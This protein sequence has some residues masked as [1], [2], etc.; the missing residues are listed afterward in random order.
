MSLKN[1]FRLLVF[2]G[3][4][5]WFTLYSRCV[6]PLA[7][8]NYTQKCFFFMPSERAAQRIFHANL[9]T[10]RMIYENAFKTKWIT[11]HN[12]YHNAKR[13]ERV[14]AGWCVFLFLLW[15]FQ[16]IKASSFRFFSFRLFSFFTQHFTPRKKPDVSNPSSL[17]LTLS[18]PDTSEQ[19]FIFVFDYRALDKSFYDRILCVKE[20]TTRTIMSTCIEM[21][22]FY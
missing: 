5:L 20:R 16:H 2:H 12:I 15:Y 19:Y 14:E 18:Q 4:F 8:K 6:F 11:H 7:R 22:L 1:Q 10:H 21:L 17:R 3:A 9:L 13:C